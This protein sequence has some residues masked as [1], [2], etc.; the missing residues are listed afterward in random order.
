[1]CTEQIVY[2]AREARSFIL[3]ET[4]LKELGVLPENFPVAGSFKPLSTE[5]VRLGDDA[6]TPLSTTAAV[7]GVV[8]NTCGCPVR[9]DVPQI[10]TNIPVEKPEANR[11]HLHRWILHYYRTYAFN[12]CPHQPIPAITG[13]AM[14]IVT[15]DGAEP[16]AIHS[17]IPTPHH[18]K[19]DVKKLLDMNCKLG[20]IE[21]VSAKDPTGCC[22]RM[23]T[24]PKKNGI[25]QE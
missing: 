21:P 14:D 20:V 3:S 4:A 2:I 15:I 13:P 22:S 9:T 10:P 16:V 24:T 1:M 25:H 8:K 18:W 6:P 12:V 11:V 19:E 7:S 23:L 17:P 5:V